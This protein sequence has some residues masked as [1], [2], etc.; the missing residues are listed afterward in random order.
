[1]RVSPNIGAG[2]RVIVTDVFGRNEATVLARAIDGH[3]TMFVK[4]HLRWAESG[5]SEW[6]TFRNEP[7]F[8]A[9][10]PGTAQYDPTIELA[11]EH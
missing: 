4:F 9:P 1:M 3:D 10:L 8:L 5:L 11:E 7:S 2:D 6:F